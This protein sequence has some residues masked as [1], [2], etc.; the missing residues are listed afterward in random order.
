MVVG[1]VYK[2]TIPNFKYTKRVLGHVSP[3]EAP[4]GD[5]H[6]LAVSA[7]D[8]SALHCHDLDGRGERGCKLA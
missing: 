1:G 5:G 8:A 3:D 4:F 6:D 2:S 7:C